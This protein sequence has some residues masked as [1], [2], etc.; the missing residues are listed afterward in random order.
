MCKDKKKGGKIFDSVIVHYLEKDSA[1]V[2]SNFFW[3]A[4]CPMMLGAILLH[5]FDTWRPELS[6]ALLTEIIIMILLY[7]IGI[8]FPNA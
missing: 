3:S 1:A 5:Y 7:S 6:F 4:L 2:T 8:K